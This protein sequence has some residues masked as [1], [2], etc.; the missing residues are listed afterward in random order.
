MP[1]HIP[2]LESWAWPWSIWTLH[3]AYLSSGPI[4]AVHYIPLLKRAWRFPAA[5]AT[6]QC[7]L[8]CRSGRC[9]V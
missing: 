9:A 7:L 2:V 3:L 4:I 6:A 1:L 5:T 8:T